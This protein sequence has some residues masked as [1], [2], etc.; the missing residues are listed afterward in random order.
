MGPLV[1]M[2]DSTAVQTANQSKAVRTA[3]RGTTSSSVIADLECSEKTISDLGLR[4]S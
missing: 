4:E 2:E 1:L 3:C